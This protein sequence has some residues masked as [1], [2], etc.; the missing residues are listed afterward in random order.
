MYTI[1]YVLTATAN[2]FSLLF[3]FTLCFLFL[4]VSQRNPLFYFCMLSGCT[5]LFSCV[6]S[7][8]SSQLCSLSIVVLSGAFVLAGC[9]EL[10]LLSSG[11]FVGTCIVLLFIVFFCVWFINKLLLIFLVCLVCLLIYTS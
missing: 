1:C 7:C 6:I 2:Y 4:M 11:D 9:C 8:N 3:S 5:L 10:V